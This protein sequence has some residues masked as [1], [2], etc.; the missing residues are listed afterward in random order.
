MLSCVFRLLPSILCGVHVNFV[1]VCPSVRCSVSFGVCVRGCA[2]ALAT[3]ALHYILMRDAL[4]EARKQ[5]TT[6][7]G[8]R[9]RI[10][11]FVCKK[12]G[13]EMNRYILYMI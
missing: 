7:D 5:H 6:K 1:F 8:D 10:D 3:N 9:D 2:R 12:D 11:E 13:K 4:K